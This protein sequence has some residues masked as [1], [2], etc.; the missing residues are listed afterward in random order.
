MLSYR[1]YLTACLGVCR[2]AVTPK[3]TLLRTPRR[4]HPVHV[5]RDGDML[6]GAHM[7]GAV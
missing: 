7:T 2:P 6:E 1:A 3:H 4:A 5:A